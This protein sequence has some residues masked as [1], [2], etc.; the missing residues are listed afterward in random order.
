MNTIQNGKGDRAR[1]NWGREWYDGYDAI[2][3]RRNAR[4]T[5]NAPHRNRSEGREQTRPE[6]SGEDSRSQE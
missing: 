3:W 1:N 6:H 2:D 5:E 4:K